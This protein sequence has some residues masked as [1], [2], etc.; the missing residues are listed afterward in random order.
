MSTVMPLSPSYL[1]RKVCPNGWISF[2]W[3]D[4]LFEGCSA[5]LKELQPARETKKST[6][7]SDFQVS[8]I[9]GLKSRKGNPIKECDLVND[10]HCPIWVK[11]S[12]ISSKA[13]C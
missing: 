1:E 8:L 7:K 13:A 10:I 9:L 3:Y 12:L 6:K 5:V 11:K 2:N 4:T